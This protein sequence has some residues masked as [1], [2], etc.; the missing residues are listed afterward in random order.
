MLAL[1]RLNS[2]FL[3]KL[4]SDK[5]KGQIGLKEKR[6]GK[7]K[8]LVLL[9]FFKGP[10]RQCEY[11]SECYTET[12]KAKLRGVYRLDPFKPKRYSYFHF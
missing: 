11:S 2:K 7:T 3:V 5:V 12:E 9:L 6:A 1:V 4:R 10:K 8:M